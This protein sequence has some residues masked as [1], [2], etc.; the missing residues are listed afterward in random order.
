MAKQNVADQFVDILARAGVKRLY[1]V[2]GDSLN[3]IVDAVRRN[4]ALDWVHVRHEETAAFAAGAEAQITGRLTA[5]AGSCGPGNL[6]LVNGLYDAHR[7]MAPV[8]AIASHIPSSEIGLGYFQ[9]THPDRLF[10]ECS[11]YCELISNPKQMPRL[12]QTAIQNAIGRSGVSV[13]ALPGD[14]ADQPAPD[15]PV[16]TALVTAR[17]TVRP[18]DA[19][20]DKLVAMIDEAER[21]TLFCGSGTA[22]AHA[23]VMELAGKIKSP[24]GHALR[25]KEW[26]QYDN[27][28]D[29][30]M[31]GLLGYGAAYEATHECDLLILLGTDFPYN[32]F[33][34]DDVTIAQVDVRPENLGRRSKLDLAVWGDVKETLRCLTPRLR[35]KQNRR[36]LDKMLKKHADAL[37]GVVKAYTRKVDKHV[38]I[39]PEYVASVLDELAD[40]EAVFTVDT[41]MCN[42]WAARYI[43]PNGRRRI[44]GSFSHGSMANALPMAIGA[45]FTD[46][47]RQVVSISGDGGF[48]MLMGDFLT[49]VQLDLPVKVVLFNNSSL[50][51]VELE[52][53]VAGLPSYGTTNQNP[54]FAAVARAC[55][56]YGIRVEK[57]KQLPGAL[58]DAFRHKGPA[59]VDIVTDPNALSIPP[60]ISREMVTG[61]ALSASKVVLDG[62]VGRMVQM[63]RSNLRNVPRP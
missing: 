61:F 2:V 24:V 44:I 29:V 17:P 34:P 56:A 6:H 42:V 3:P 30:G 62:G 20:I 43:S 11:H 53:M 10:Q 8:L 31:S 19:E 9:E 37:E 32:A 40:P 16:Q 21:V 60:R 49:L 45:Q 41:G 18:S 50:G 14:I 12:L 54:D 36:F 4:A 1:G 26:I 39:H 38:P 15:K 7:S 13:V 52:M 55:G 47:N 28:F 63:A 59:L 5:C 57:P 51:M 35:P 48:S 23:E 27:P 33:L 22:G 58:K 46:R 25:G